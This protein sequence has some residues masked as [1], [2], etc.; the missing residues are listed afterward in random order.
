MNRRTSLL[1]VLCVVGAAMFAPTTASA[2]WGRPE[3]VSWRKFNASNF[4]SF[5]NRPDTTADR[6]EDVKVDTSGIFNVLDADFPGA[7]GFAVTSASANDSMTFAF[8]QI[9]SDTNVTAT[10][11]FKGAT[12]AVQVNWG[13]GDI[14]W[15]TGATMTCAMADGVKQW[16]IPLFVDAKEAVNTTYNY[17]TST[18]ANAVSNQIGW[19]FA[20]AMRVIFTGAASTTVPSAK[21]R[22]VKYRAAGNNASGGT[23]NW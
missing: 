2:R 16:S 8:I 1:A 13:K 21:I 19:Q 3:M 20:P 14:S 23:T 5:P 10:C 18:T 7:D 4:I 9:Y 11:N 12:A 22:V 6:L 15:Q 17:V